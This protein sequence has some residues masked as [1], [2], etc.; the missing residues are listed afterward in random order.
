MAFSTYPHHPIRPFIAVLTVNKA[1]LIFNSLQVWFG[2]N[3]LIVLT[4]VGLRN[5]HTLQPAI[6]LVLP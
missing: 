1:D 4:F 6:F 3:G 5:T 2:S